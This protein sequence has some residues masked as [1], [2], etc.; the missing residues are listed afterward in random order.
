LVSASLLAIP[1]VHA[2]STLVGGMGFCMTYSP[3]C[4]RAVAVNQPNEIFVSVESNP[5]IGGIPPTGTVSSS[6]SCPTGT[7]GQCGSFTAGSQ[8]VFVPPNSCQLIPQF[9]FTN[10]GHCSIAYTANP[11]TE[12]TH[13]FVI[14]YNGDAIYA[15]M[16]VTG[17]M[18]VIQRSTSTSISCMASTLTDHHSTPCTAVVT[19]TSPGTPITPSG[20]FAWKSS[21]KGTFGPNP[22]T[23]SGAG[24]TATCIVTFTAAPG[25]SLPQTITGTY[26]GDTDH[27]GSSGT[28]P[29]STP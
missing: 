10:D 21:G 5:P 20:T 4:D 15:S 29:I 22:C 24:G 18:D 8:G 2:G 27:S 28:T 13:G 3:P 7:D 25:K 12:G 14:T 26:S 17:A 19:D 6:V 16:S 9:G 1:A 23:L 11:G